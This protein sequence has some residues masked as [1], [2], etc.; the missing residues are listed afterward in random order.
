MNNTVNHKQIHNWWDGKVIIDEITEY[1]DQRGCLIELWRTD[2]Y[3]MNDDGFG[4]GT[5]PTM[6]YWSVTKPMVVRGPHQHENQTDW[7]ITMKGLMVYQLYNP[8]NGEMKH[9]ITNPD[10]VTRVKVAPP[11][12]HSYRNL[13]TKECLSGNF[14]TALFMGKDKKGYTPTQKIDEIRHEH[15]VERADCRTV[16]VFGS[17]GRLGK[18]LV[19][20]LYK[21]MGYHTYNVVPVSMK[22]N[23]DMNDIKNL[24]VV[25]D[26]IKQNK[27]ANDVIVNCM[28]KTDVQ[29][30]EDDF[31]FANFRLPKFLAEFCVANGLYF[32]QFSTDYVFQSGETSKYTQSKMMF[33][34]WY[35]STLPI[36][37]QY[38]TDFKKLVKI[39]RIAN[40]FSQD[41]SDTRNLLN[42]VYKSFLDN[43]LKSP[44][45][46]VIMP[47]DVEVL[48]EFLVN[49]Y[50]FELD[51]HAPIT[52]VSGKP[53]SIEDLVEKFI[54]PDE[55][56]IVGVV[57]SPKTVNNPKIFLETA[58][59]LNCDLNILNK[60]VSLK[61]LPKA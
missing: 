3:K 30:Q 37:N 12:I 53:Y 27:K 35:D 59:L 21:K 22:I 23:N 9:F 18:S 57:D 46:L 49:E 51:N 44:Q 55:P 45:N 43:N 50:L 1:T 16:W 54:E 28:A 56:V 61:S 36:E 14:P 17:N 39:V 34:I 11:I 32:V 42:K 7:F 47:T 29:N 20:K 31:E 58:R 4:G 41:V 25:L 10:K 5:V 19:N 60:F 52:N 2:D 15:V 24:E 8:D 48:S 26:F 38:E 13:S 40:L 6:S 33:E